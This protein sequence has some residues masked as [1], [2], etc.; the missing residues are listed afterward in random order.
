MGEAEPA[1]TAN[2]D[3]N[4]QEGRQ[5]GALREWVVLTKVSS[6]MSP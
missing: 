3:E 5:G 4:W 2:E 6:A 1:R